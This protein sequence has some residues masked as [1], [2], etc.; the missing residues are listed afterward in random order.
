MNYGGWIGTA[1]T[2]CR[3]LKLCAEQLKRCRLCSC[4]GSNDCKLPKQDQGAAHIVL[5]SRKRPRTM[6]LDYN[7]SIFHP[8]YPSCKKLRVSGSGD[9]HVENI[10]SSTHMYHFNGASKYHSGCKDYYK[11]GW[12]VDLRK[13]ETM[14]DSVIFIGNKNPFFQ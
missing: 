6:V 13:P 10:S 5:A 4:D 3:T 1:Q 8:A 12:F 7:Q 2:A 9:V 11:H 14:D